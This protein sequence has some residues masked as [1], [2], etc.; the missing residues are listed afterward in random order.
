MI[1]SYPFF[2]YEDDEWVSRFGGLLDEIENPDIEL[3]ATVIFFDKSR[4]SQL[5]TFL[6]QK[7]KLNGPFDFLGNN[8]TQNASEGDYSKQ[9]K[10]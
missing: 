10:S 1:E 7:F 5:V 8:L 2:S 3:S 4:P 6:E 9:E